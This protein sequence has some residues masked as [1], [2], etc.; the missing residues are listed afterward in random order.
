MINLARVLKS[1]LA[2]IQLLISKLSISTRMIITCILGSVAVLTMR[3]GLFNISHVFLFFMT[4]AVVL[5][6]ELSNR[7]IKIGTLMSFLFG[8]LLVGLYPYSVLG[9]TV[10]ILIVIAII[11]WAFI[12][13][14]AKYALSRPETYFN[15]F[16][17][18][19]LWVLI[20]TVSW[21][22]KSMVIV[23][24]TITVTV[25]VKIFQLLLPD[26]WTD[27]HAKAYAFSILLP[28]ILTVSFSVYSHY[29]SQ[30]IDLDGGYNKVVEQ[31]MINTVE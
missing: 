11:T 23:N 15:Y 21:L 25:I 27:K 16:N 28:S 5:T 6:I 3:S 26:N 30:N 19:I 12:I 14:C 9:S 20:F 29:A 4:L 13:G 18:T 10:Y 17:N 7:M 1:L 2:P 8:M 22:T 31:V 24:V